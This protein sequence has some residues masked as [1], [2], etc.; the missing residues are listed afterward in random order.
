MTAPPSAARRP[1]SARRRGACTA[2]CPRPGRPA[3][4]RLFC[5]AAQGEQDT[6]AGVARA[7]RGRGAG[8]RHFFGLGG[9]GVARAWRGRGAG[10]TR[11][12][13]IPPSQRCGRRN[14]V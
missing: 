6:G 5:R 8:Y 11:I 4:V 12:K 14:L 2:T 9:A 7:W 1:T 10:I 13:N 3:P